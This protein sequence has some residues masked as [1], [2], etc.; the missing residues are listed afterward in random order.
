MQGVG[1][2]IA[3]DEIDVGSSIPT[4]QL[5]ILLSSQLSNFPAFKPALRATRNQQRV[6]R[7]P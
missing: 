6:A 4:S 3:E 1:I 2:R 7:N 5:P